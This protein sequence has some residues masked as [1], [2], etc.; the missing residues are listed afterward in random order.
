V[1]KGSLGGQPLAGHSVRLVV[2]THHRNGPAVGDTISAQGSGDSG[3]LDASTFQVQAS[4]TGAIAGVVNAVAGTTIDVS[5]TASAGSDGEGDQGPA[6][7]LSRDG[8]DGGDFTVDASQASV[9]VDGQ[10]GSLPDITAG[11]TVGVLGAADDGS[12]LA[13]QVLAFSTTQDTAEGTITQTNG[14][15]LTL[16]SGDGAGDA[17]F[18]GSSVGTVD[19]TTSQVF[20][21]GQP[22]AAG[23]LVTGDLVLALG[24]AGSDPLAATVTFAFSPGGD[25]QG[26]G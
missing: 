15:L 20:L 17:T 14:N 24:T 12:M 11:E 3:E 7:G 19:V 22:G 2:G 23:Q 5:V 18:D 25:G 16:S 8:H 9:S 21:D 10:P 4:D 13:T 26:D 1:G 6:S